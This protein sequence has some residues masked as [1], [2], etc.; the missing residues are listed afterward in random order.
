MQAQI[1]NPVKKIFK[2][3]STKLAISISLGCLF[4][5]VLFFLII[6]KIYGLKYVAVK[7]I[8]TPTTPVIIPDSLISNT[9]DANIVVTHLA[10]PKPV[11]AIYMTS[12]VAGDLSFKNKLIKSIDDTEL[13]SVIVDVKDTTGK[14]SFAVND[15]NL[16]KINSAENRIKD[17]RSFIDQLHKKNIY[18]IGRIAVFQDPFWAKKFPSD[19][20]KTL[21]NKSALWQDNKCK[22]AIRRGHEKD[23]TYWIDS[24]SKDYWNYIAE[25][26][27]EAYALGFDELNFDY[28]RFPADGNMKDIYFPV[29]EGKVKS[30]VMTSFTKFLHD[31]FAGVNDEKTP[32]P[33][34]SADIFGLVTTEIDDLGIGQLLIPYATNF[35]YIMPMVYPSH[36]APDTYG[37]KNPAIKPYEVVNFAIK[38][39]VLR[40]KN[41]NLDPYKL[42]PWL[43]DFNLGAIYTPEMVRDQ[44]KAT[45]DAGLDSWALWDP[46]NTYTTN[47]LLSS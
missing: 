24:G 5:I 32:R 9:L 14:I 30:D 46:A 16:K 20:V 35:D 42:R 43:Q 38:K 22:R 34:I 21:S 41:A 29:S 2:K 27:D 18:V 1:M 31:H 45:Y 39:A 36:F 26:G 6:P 37:Y 15:P 25:V 40:L 47:A 19:A 10:T 33:K 7:P 12:W 23:C 3:K 13:N 11:K 44:I 4:S 17:V 8:A 28:I